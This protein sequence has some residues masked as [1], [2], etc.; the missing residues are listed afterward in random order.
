MKPYLSV[1]FNLQWLNVIF[2]LIFYI[3][4]CVIN[5]DLW[6]LI[7]CISLGSMIQGVLFFTWYLMTGLESFY[8][9]I[10]LVPL[11]GLGY[12]FSI[13]FIMSLHHWVSFF[14]LVNTLFIIPF[15]TVIAFEVYGDKDDYERIGFI[16]ILK[17]IINMITHMSLVSY[18]KIISWIAI[19]KELRLNKKRGNTVP[20]REEDILVD[21][22]NTKDK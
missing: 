17:T 12:I 3:L 11:G 4:H 19:F 7:I 14:F 8:A 10:I 9:N 2:F 18:K 15:G 5:Q 21:K 22:N 13:L 16:S 20:L 1:L 6:K